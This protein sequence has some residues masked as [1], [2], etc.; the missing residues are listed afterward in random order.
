MNFQDRR[1]AGRRLAEELSAYRD[2]DAVV[3]AL[4]R[5]GVPVAFEVARA[6][7]LPLGLF[8]VRKLGTP[9]QVELALGAIASGGVR[10]MN[11]DVLRQINLTEAQ[12]QQII[13]REEAELRRRERLYIGDATPISVRQRTVIVVD[14]GLATGATMRAAVAALRSQA[15][16]KIVVAVPVGSAESCERLRAE[17]DEVVCLHSPTNFIGV[18]RWYADFSQTT[19]AEVRALMGVS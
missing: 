18:G 7:A 8:L 11:R 4:P 3:L 16:R 9:G 6:L 1:E 2:A 14:D 15:P 12:L 19:D 10:V 17:A 5:G 13:D